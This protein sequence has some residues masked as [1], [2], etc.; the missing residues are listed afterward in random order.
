MAEADP[1]IDDQRRLGDMKIV[2][3]QDESPPP[4]HG[5]SHQHR[6]VADALAQ[7]DR[8][9]LGR[10]IELHQQVRH[11]DVGG[12]LVDDDPHRPIRRM[13]TDVD[14]RA[15]EALVGHPRHR[16][17]ELAIEEVGAGERGL[18]GRVC[19]RHGL[20]LALVRCV[21]QRTM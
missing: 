18:P 5:S 7:A 10:H 17:Q 6:H 4:L 15:R 13:G 9:G 1:V 20:M 16:D 14:H 21:V 19:G 11:A 2:R 12:R 8:I 3:V